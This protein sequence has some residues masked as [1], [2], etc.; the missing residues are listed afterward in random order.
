MCQHGMER[1]GLW[2][3]FFFDF[4]FILQIQSVGGVAT[5]TGNLY[6]KTCCYYIGEGSFSVFS[7]VPTSHTGKQKKNYRS[8]H[9]HN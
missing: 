4:I 8:I 2:R 9:L 7:D 1:E 3:P 5:N 6:F